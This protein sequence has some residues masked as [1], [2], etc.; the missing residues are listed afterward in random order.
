[1][2]GFVLFLQLI[3]C[4]LLVIVV[5]MQSGRG[6]GLTETFAS[7]ESMFG[8]KTSEFLVKATYILGTSFLVCC[9][10][11]AVL[12]SRKEQS[13]MANTVS[14]PLPKGTQFPLSMPLPAEPQ[15]A[16]TPGEPASAPQ[17]MGVPPV[18]PTEAAQPSAPAEPAPESA[19]VPAESK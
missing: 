12:S 18:V 10:T 2:Y 3:I 8:A 16:E 11:L 6:G 19:P 4:V 13:L 7:A 15:K 5:L 1:M 17:S 14:V 9:L